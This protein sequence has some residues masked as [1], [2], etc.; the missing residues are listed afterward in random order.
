MFTFSS[1]EDIN[2]DDI[3]FYATIS[4]CLCFVLYVFISLH[5]QVWLLMLE[6]I[7]E[8]IKSFMLDWIVT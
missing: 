8:K 6:Y 5:K 2:N 7:L 3:R 4:E 1:N